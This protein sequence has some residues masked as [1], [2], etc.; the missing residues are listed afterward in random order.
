LGRSRKAIWAIRIPDRNA[1]IS[2][3]DMCAAERPEFHIEIVTPVIGMRKSEIV[4]RGME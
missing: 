2:F 1:H 3:R 4:T